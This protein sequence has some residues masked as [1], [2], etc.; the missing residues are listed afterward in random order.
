M[1]DPAT[2]YGWL[3]EVDNSNL[4]NL[5]FRSLVRQAT[6]ALK[7]NQPAPLVFDTLKTFTEKS[8]DRYLIYEGRLLLALE[9]HQSGENETA[10]LFLG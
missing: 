6:A 3:D 1:R 9:A 8:Q 5:V 4:Q 10:L 2:V 7:A